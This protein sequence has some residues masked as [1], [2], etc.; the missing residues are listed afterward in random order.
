MAKRVNEPEHWENYGKNR[1]FVRLFVGMLES[2]AMKKL[3]GRQIALY[4]YMKKQYNGKESVFCFNWK[5][6]ND[7][8]KLYTNQST[9]YKDIKKLC[10]LGFITCIENNRNLRQKNKYAFSSNWQKIQ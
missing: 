4:L 10:D 5:L 2:P 7:K 1:K 6:A 9:F 8:Y 3:N